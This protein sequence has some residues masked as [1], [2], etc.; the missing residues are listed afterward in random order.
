MDPA[1]CDRIQFVVLGP[2]TQNMLAFQLFLVDTELPDLRGEES[3]GFQFVRGDPSKGDRETVSFPVPAATRLR[4][5]NEIKVVFR[6]P[7]VMSKS[8]KIAIERMT[9]VPR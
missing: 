5:F 9:I 2:D 3:L 7:R 6:Q 8:V 4:R 1:S